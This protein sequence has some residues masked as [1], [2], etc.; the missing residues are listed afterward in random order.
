M[1]NDRSSRW[2]RMH[3]NSL[4]CSRFRPKIT[5][6]PL[7]NMPSIS[8]PLCSACSQSSDTVY[9]T[10]SRVIASWL[11]YVNRTINEVVLP[12]SKLPPLALTSAHVEIV[13]QH[14][15]PPNPQW[16]PVCGWDTHYKTTHSC[17][18]MESTPPPILPFPLSMACASLAHAHTCTFIR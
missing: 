5:E 4:A 6:N 9:M 8:S 18:V 12:A 11:V 10:A 17:Y 3:P 15:N 14:E 1:R 16:T 7:I 13:F 2:C